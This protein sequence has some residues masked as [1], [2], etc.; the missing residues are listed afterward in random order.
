MSL[1]GFPRS[2]F[3]PDFDQGFKLAKRGF[4]FAYLIQAILGLGLVGVVIYVAAH[5]LAKV[6]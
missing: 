6:W 3:E 5:F 4:A 2:P 1:P